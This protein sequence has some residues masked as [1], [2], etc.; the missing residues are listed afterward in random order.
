MKRIQQFEKPPRDAIDH[1]EAPAGRKYKRRII[2]RPE[3]S[4]AMSYHNG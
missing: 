2:P 1:P 3:I 4:P